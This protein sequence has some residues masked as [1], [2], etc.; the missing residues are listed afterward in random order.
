MKRKPPVLTAAFACP[1]PLW[2]MIRSALPSDRV[3][4]AGVSTSIRMFC[5]AALLSTMMSI[6]TALALKPAHENCTLM[7]RGLTTDGKF[8]TSTRTR[9]PCANDAIVG[10][11]LCTMGVGTGRYWKDLSA[12]KVLPRL[13]R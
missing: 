10:V 9:D 6:T 8:F 2:N 5:R 3:L 12:N 11:T 7:S 13:R 4:P 1:K